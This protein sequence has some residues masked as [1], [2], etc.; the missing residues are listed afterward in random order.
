MSKKVFEVYS[1]FF[2]PNNVSN[3]FDQ[4]YFKKAES[5]KSFFHD[6]QKYLEN[7]SQEFY[8]C[9]DLHAFVKVHYDGKELE[10]VRSS[11]EPFWNEYVGVESKILFFDMKNSVDACLMDMALILKENKDCLKNFM[12]LTPQR[13]KDYSDI[14]N[15]LKSVGVHDYDRKVILD[16]H[17]FAC[18]SP[19]PVDFV[20]FDNDCYSG[21]KNTELLCFNSVK[22]KNNFN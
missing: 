18:S 3:E 14:V 5:L 16:G 13:T 2:W 15:M 1:E 8:S 6:L 19:E 21:A 4:L 7:P 9:A 22:G 11:I 10:N 12:K 20:T 17:D